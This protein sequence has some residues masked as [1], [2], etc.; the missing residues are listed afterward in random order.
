MTNAEP[1][2]RAVLAYT[3]LTTTG[4]RTGR[5]H[6][7]EIWFVLRDR[8]LFLLSGGGRRSDWVR[9]LLADP[10]VVLKLGDSTHRGVARLVEGSPEDD[11]IRKA[12][13]AKYQ[14]W[15]EGKPLGEWARTSPVIEIELG[16]AEPTGAG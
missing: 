6:T 5:L 13:A 12:V 2:P 10:N 7:V 16:D 11:P 15:R 4:R 8:R 9:N 1:D 3:Y 14:G